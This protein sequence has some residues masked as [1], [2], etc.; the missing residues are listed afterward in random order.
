MSKWSIG[1]RKMGRGTASWWEESRIDEKGGREGEKEGRE[2]DSAEMA[3]PLRVH[4]RLFRSAVQSLFVPALMA[5][6]GDFNWWPM[7]FPPPSLID[8]EDGNSLLEHGGERSDS[9]AAV[10]PN[11]SSQQ[12]R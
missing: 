5:Y 6:L 4:A 7:R 2:R 12:A 10:E 9:A 11:V 3:C 8:A 1:D